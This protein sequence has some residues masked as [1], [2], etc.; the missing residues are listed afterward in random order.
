MERV[1]DVRALSVAYGHVEAIHGLDLTLSRGEVV[2]ILGPNGAGKSTLLNALMGSLAVRDG[3]VSLFGRPI[4][5]LDVEE[6]VALGL[7][8]VPE[9]RELFVTMS[10][11]DNLR[12]GA[13][14]LR[15]EGRTEALLKRMWDLFPRLLERR[16]QMAGTLSGG[17]RQMLAMA[18][19]LMGEPKVLMLG[20]PS[21]GLAPLI[22]QD[23]LSIV[24]HLRE[25]GVS[26]LLVEQNARAALRVADRAYVL[27]GGRIV[28]E[29][30]AADL[31]DD[32]RIVD[33]Y[34]GATAAR[35]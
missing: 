13:F 33:A 8:L 19:A 25:L 9:K 11:E 32:P 26:V 21:L 31:A 10:V 7:S 14:R 15:R 22:V 5:R 12:L 29:G 16:D 6:R 18:R 20:E 1:L 27:E 3:A 17:E 35:G 4:R 34:L 30:A 2:T 24:A 28:L 23:I